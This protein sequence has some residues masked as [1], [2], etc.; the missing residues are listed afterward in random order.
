MKTVG[1]IPVRYES[2]RFPGKPLVQIEGKTVLAH[3]YS[4]AV[5]CRSLDELIIATDDERIRKE[6]D[7]FGAEC[8]MSDTRH[9]CGTERIA[10]AVSG[11]DA[12]IIVNIQGDEL[13]I[14]PDDISLAVDALLSDSD[15][16]CGTVCNEITEESDFDDPNLVKAVLDS[17]GCA[18]YFSRS[19][20]PN[21]TRDEHIT[22]YGLG[23]IGVY[24]FRRDALAR[25]VSLGQSELEKVEKLEQLRLIEHGMKIKV[26][27]TKS[28]NI[29]LNTPQDVPQARN[30][31]KQQEG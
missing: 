5:R 21:R 13:T 2:S 6:A 31:L 24:A 8:F 1:I 17:N 3:V 22:V 16:A 19:P 25:F 7:T 18:I 28:K 12:D 4:R 26:N 11:R 27:L 29:S 14:N 10:E 23:H 15:I 9:S 30:I 20:I